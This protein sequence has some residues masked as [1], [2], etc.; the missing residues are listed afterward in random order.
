MLSI[1]SDAVVDL[2]CRYADSPTASPVSMM[3]YFDSPLPYNLQG[4][5]IENERFKMLM[6]ALVVALTPLWGLSTLAIGVEWLK[7]RE[8]KKFK[9][10]LVTEMYHDEVFFNEMLDNGVV[11]AYSNKMF[12]TDGTDTIADKNS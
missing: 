9:G 6:M 5:W 10:M 4:Y 12:Y 7:Y 3:P 2:F 1:D 11:T 8:I